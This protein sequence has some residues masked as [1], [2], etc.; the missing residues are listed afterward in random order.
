MSNLRRLRTRYFFAVEGEGEQSFVKYL[1][2]ISD[3]RGL[4]V[5][6]GCHILNGGGYQSMLEK[7]I[8]IRRREAQKRGRIHKSVLLVDADRKE[9]RDDSWN[10]MRLRQ[11]AQKNAFLLCLQTPNQEG[12]LLR[13]HKGHEAKSYNAAKV[14]EKILKQ[15]PSYKKPI[16][17]AQLSS[18]FTIDDL[19]RSAKYDA[20]LAALL[21]IIGVC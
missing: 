15:W 8:K 7:A 9:F 6:L 17:A 2:Q 18:R 20:E 16:N 14:K 4:S 10:H 5:H 3:Q 13:M 11:E 1:Q 12:V 19:E 21:K